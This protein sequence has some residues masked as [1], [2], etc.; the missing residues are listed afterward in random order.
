MK[1]STNTSTLIRFYRASSFTEKLKE[2]YDEGIL[3]PDFCWEE[4]MQRRDLPEN[5]KMMKDET[6]FLIV[7]KLSLSEM[8]RTVDLID[9]AYGYASLQ[10]D[11]EEATAISM[12]EFRGA[13]DTL[14]DDYVA[15]AL[16]HL[17]E[18]RVSVLSSLDV[19][20]KMVGKNVLKARDPAEFKDLVAKFE[21]ECKE[22]FS[23]RK[24]DKLI[25]E[26]Y[27]TSV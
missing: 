17:T 19:L 23:R 13:E 27:P 18:L 4:L 10:L 15:L 11:M 7:V 12:G 25:R 14:S 2:L 3:I 1:A 8:E 5:Q 20:A 26:L 22:K 6:V 9:F 21:E 24:L 16:P